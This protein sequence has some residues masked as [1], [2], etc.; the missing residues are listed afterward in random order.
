MSP[1]HVFQRSGQ[2]RKEAEWVGSTQRWMCFLGGGGLFSF[3]PTKVTEIV[4]ALEGVSGS[5]R[6][7]SP[8][9]RQTLRFHG[10]DITED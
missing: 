4:G 10:P 8:F 1:T 5:F 6:S 3:Q 9:C 2:Q 7:G